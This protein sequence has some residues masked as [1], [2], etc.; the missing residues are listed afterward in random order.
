MARPTKQ[1]IDYFPLD[2]DFFSD[3]KIRK[4]SRGCGVKAPS[5]LICLLCN[6]YKDNGYYIEWD[7]DLPF[8]IADTVGVT[9]GQV[10]EVISKA[11]QV[12]FFDKNLFEKFSILTSEGIQKRF[13][14]ATYQRKEIVINPD[15]LVNSTKK[16]IN[17]AN[18]AVNRTNNFQPQMSCLPP[19]EH[20]TTELSEKEKEQL[21][22][23]FFFERNCSNAQAELDRFV[24]YYAANGW[25]RKDSKTPVRDRIALAK[26]WKVE[27]TERRWPVVVAEWLCRIYLHDPSRG[28]FLAK[29]IE[30]VITRAGS[31]P[32]VTLQCASKDVADYIESSGIQPKTIFKLNYRIKR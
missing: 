5:I 25:C 11:I 1:G 12:E 6:I 17:C 7:E 2:V 28:I 16:S 26:L 24:T 21:F 20:S 23:F 18:N 4:I 9:E 19:M 14:L 30:D 31:H 29:G 10:S 27:E 15:Y 32:E 3:V 22:C 13:R 8:V